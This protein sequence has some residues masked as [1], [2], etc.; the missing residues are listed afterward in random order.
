M[1]GPLMKLE[2]LLSKVLK[3]WGAR[4]GGV[5]GSLAPIFITVTKSHPKLAPWAHTFMSNPLHPKISKTSS[6]PL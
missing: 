1:F 5:G 6:E 2:R 4:G 3:Q